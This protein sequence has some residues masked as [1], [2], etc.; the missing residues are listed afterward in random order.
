MK[1]I[2]YILCMLL[3]SVM[4]AACTSDDLVEN[5]GVK[6]GHDEKGNYIYVTV[7]AGVPATPQSRG[8][9]GQYFMDYTWKEVAKPKIIVLL[10]GHRSELTLVPNSIS[11]DMKSAQFEG[12]L[13]YGNV[14]PTET[15]QLRAYI[16]TYFTKINND[17]TYEMTNPTEMNYGRVEKFDVVNN[18][19]VN[20]RHFSDHGVFYA[21][22]NYSS[23]NLTF[24]FSPKTAVL[25]FHVDLINIKGYIDSKLSAKGLFGPFQT[26]VPGRWSLNGK[27]CLEL[28]CIVDTRYPVS[29]MKLSLIYP[30][31]RSIERRIELA[32]PTNR[33][34][35]GKIYHKEINFAPQV[36]DYL[37]SSGAWGDLL[38]NEMIDRKDITGIVF[39]SGTSSYYHEENKVCGM[40]G[41]A[42]SLKDLYNYDQFFTEYGQT[43]SYTN[44]YNNT[45]TADQI[46]DNSNTG[47]SDWGYI[48][49]G[50][51]LDLDDDG[52]GI[53][54][55]TGLGFSNALRSYYAV[56]IA[57]NYLTYNYNEWYLPSAVEMK[58]IA[59][60]MYGA[61]STV[62]SDTE[63]TFSS[64]NRSKLKTQIDRL[65]GVATFNDLD[66]TYWTTNFLP[67]STSDNT[68]GWVAQF[69]QEKTGN[70]LRTM[71]ITD[72]KERAKIRP[73]TRVGEFE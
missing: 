73:V 41:L 65:A 29:D 69:D 12:R 35:P 28:A 54:Y 38:P 66:G 49:I 39:V 68:I 62:K 9:D 15:T 50:E 14:V 3:T 43:I 71:S 5:D 61:T 63:I 47:R 8:I 46:N 70:K 45:L 22:T 60:N 19:I 26:V 64:F 2:S 37:Y 53:T 34:E 23:T 6:M 10:D 72:H 31:G 30:D 16:E 11:N 1:K 7:S 27:N 40:Y 42:V 48:K 57:H 21:E 55:H 44:I 25:Y 24:N 58:L 17:G 36:G 13:Y 56:S 32:N 33:L 4:F 59:K 18:N 67:F 51:P 52:E 20:F